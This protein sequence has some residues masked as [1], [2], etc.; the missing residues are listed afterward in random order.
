MTESNYV[1]RY[2]MVRLL[3]LDPMYLSKNDGHSDQDFEK[4]VDEIVR[5]KEAEGRSKPEALRDIR[6][7]I[8]PQWTWDEIA[9]FISDEAERL[10][11]SAYCSTTPQ[12]DVTSTMGRA[13]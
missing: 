9:N 11:A 5:L 8:S 2:D 13:K 4:I 1:Y 10:E 12:S 7:R 3:L 6:R